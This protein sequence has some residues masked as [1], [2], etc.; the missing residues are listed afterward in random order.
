MT[1]AEYDLNPQYRRIEDFN[2]VF[3]QILTPAINMDK[4]TRIHC[5]E[6]EYFVT[7]SSNFSRYS[8]EGQSSI[9]MAY[10][11]NEC[12]CERRRRKHL[13]GLSIQWGPINETGSV[14]NISSKVKI[15][16]YFYR[17]TY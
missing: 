3:K 12:L 9:G 4:L 10:S 5:L 15:F 17:Y 14:E 8:L 11:A 7:F 2:T 13:P 1:L 6:L 16:N